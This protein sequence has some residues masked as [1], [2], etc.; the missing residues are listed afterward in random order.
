MF[1]QDVFKARTRHRF[2]VGIEEQLWCG[3]FTPYSKP[4]SQHCRRFLPQGQFPFTPAL[5]AHMDQRMRMQRELIPAH[6]DEL[7]DPK[8]S[9]K[10]QMQHRTIARATSGVGIGSIKQRLHFLVRE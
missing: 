4:G 7:G 2:S 5:P 10:S 3:V 6:S 1:V 9:S 8:A